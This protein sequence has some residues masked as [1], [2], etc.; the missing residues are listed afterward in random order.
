MADALATQQREQMDKPV[1]NVVSD[2]C[3]LKIQDKFITRDSQKWIMQHSGEVQIKDYYKKKYGWSTSTFQEIDWKL[4]H[5]VLRSFSRNDLLKFVH[6]WLPTNYRLFRE[7]QE[8][9]PACRLCGALEETNDH[10][11]LCTHDSQVRQRNHISNYLW[12]DNENH[13]NAE[14]NNIIELATMESPLNPSWKPDISAIS[15]ELKQCMIQQNKIGW[16]H[17]FK[18][19]VAKE[20]TLFMEEHYRGLGIDSKRYTGTRW[21]KMLLTNIWNMILTLWKQR[22][23][24]VHGISTENNIKTERERLRNRIIKY[25]EI[26]ESLEVEDREKLLL[27]DLESMLSEDTRYIKTWLKMVQRIIRASKMD[28][29]TTTNSRKLMETFVNWRPAENKVK[30]RSR[31]V[32]RSPADTHPD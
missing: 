22:N 20:M 3:L 26:A 19:R 31:T 21:G 13:G 14:L 1:I 5:R 10:L 4:Q 12:R 11:L 15:H 17:L 8:S 27:K 24:E 28:K 9:S 18:G 6:E 30:R 2:S 7:G 29:Q 25:Y 23:E 32:A 16:Q